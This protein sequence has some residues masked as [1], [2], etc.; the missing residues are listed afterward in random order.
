MREE[1]LAQC[2]SE[3]VCGCPFALCAVLAP[4]E[5][6][7]ADLPRRLAERDLL[8]LTWETCVGA[9]SSAQGPRARHGPVRPILFHP[10]PLNGD[11]DSYAHNTHVSWHVVIGKVEEQADRGFSTHHP[12]PVSSQNHAR[13]VARAHLARLAQGAPDAR[14]TK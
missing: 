2:L 11:S 6:F 3:P 4:G 7:Q 9:G 12:S 13:P 5:R 1:C 8:W 14:V 10:M